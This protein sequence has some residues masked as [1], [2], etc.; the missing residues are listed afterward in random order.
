MCGLGPA[1]DLVAGLEGAFSRPPRFVA[2]AV[3]QHMFLSATVHVAVVPEVRQLG[4]HTLASF[5]CKSVLEP[6]EVMRCLMPL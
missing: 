1:A 3:A 2:V 6:L 5:S 4:V